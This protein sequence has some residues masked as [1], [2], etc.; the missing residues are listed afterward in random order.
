[1]GA[2]RVCDIEEVMSGNQAGNE[3]REEVSYSDPHSPSEMTGVCRG[4]GCEGEGGDKREGGGKT[5]TG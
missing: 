2:V 5:R 3:R 4:R 1:M